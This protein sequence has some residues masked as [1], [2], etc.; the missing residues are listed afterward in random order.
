MWDWIDPVSFSPV[1]IHCR[2]R[3]H[4]VSGVSCIRAN[5]DL[6]FTLS[7]LLFCS[8]IDKNLTQPTR[9]SPNAYLILTWSDRNSDRFWSQTDSVGQC[10]LSGSR[11]L[12]LSLCII[13]RIIFATDITC[14]DEGS[15]WSPTG[16][17]PLIFTHHCIIQTVCYVVAFR[18]CRG[19]LSAVIPGFIGRVFTEF[20][21]KWSVS[22]L[23]E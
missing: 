13:F 3:L 21:V 17:M 9:L 18:T 23:R 12:L 11:C 15:L 6:A 2:F 19:N 1:L 4:L 22:K 8:S 7:Q 16:L 10:G 20:T 14:S 5:S